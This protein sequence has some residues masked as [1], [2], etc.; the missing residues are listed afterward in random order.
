[1]SDTSAELLGAVFNPPRPIA[2]FSF[3]STTGEPFT[4]SDHSGEIVLLFFGYL[5]CPDFCPLTLA[6]MRQVYAALDEPSNRLTIVFVTVDPERDMIA[7]LDIYLGQFHEDFVGIRE[8]GERLE[9]LM[10]QFGV[11][12]QQQPLDESPQLYL[13]AHTAS[14]FLINPDG[15]LEMQYLYGTDFRD[16]VH[17]LEIL[18]ATDES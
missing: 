8:E 9:Q 12:A 18:L 16:I 2:D 4:L 11:V 10:N 5:S 15:E 7:D 17:D 3:A 6:Q 1:V 14:I 13:V